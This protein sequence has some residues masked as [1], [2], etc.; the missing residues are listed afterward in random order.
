MALKG[1]IAGRGDPAAETPK[2]T[3]RPTAPPPRATRSEEPVSCID[4]GTEL[5]GTIRCGE[6]LRVD[7]SIEGEIHCKK[8][9]IVGQEARLH[10]A[11]EA[12]EVSVAGEVKGDI[13]ASSKITLRAT[14][15]VVGDLSTPGIVIEEGAKL[16]GRIHIGAELKP[17]AA[18]GS[19]AQSERKA[20]APSGQSPPPKAS[21]P[22]SA[23][24]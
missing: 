15:R 14:A 24:V 7:G 9:L 13:S 17:E 22:A 6:T 5:V 18:T 19:A 16:E 2:D 20:E 11:I 1:F 23:T 4:A 21:R 12:A 3:P 10:A 8:D